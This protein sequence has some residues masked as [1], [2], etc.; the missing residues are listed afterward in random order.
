[1]LMLLG[2]WWWMNRQKAVTAPPVARHEQI[3][4]APL[5]TPAPVTAQT[6]AVSPAQ[7]TPVA[8][9]ATGHKNNIL[10]KTTGNRHEHPI[11]PQTNNLPPVYKATNE[12]QQLAVNT[13][14]NNELPEKHGAL[15]EHPRNAININT[16]RAPGRGTLISRLINTNR[17]EDENPVAQLASY[18]RNDQIDVLNT[19]VNKKTV[20]RGILRKASR[21]IVKKTSTDDDTDDDQKHIL[22]GS[23]AIAVK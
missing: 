13:P 6:T 2:G 18:E 15:P 11:T 17:Q 4:P 7:L 19:S 16:V 22:I 12:D 5:Q 14:D 9:T 21:I 1:V 23:F 8:T 10:V 3:K 20:L